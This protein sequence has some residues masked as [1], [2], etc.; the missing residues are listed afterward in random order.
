MTI[1]DFGANLASSK[2]FM[3]GMTSRPE[4]AERVFKWWD[5][6]IFVFLSI[7]SLGAILSFLLNWFS[8]ED[9]LLHPVSFPLMTAILLVILTNNQGRWFLLYYMRKPRP[10]TPRPGWKV[11]VVTTFVPNGEPLEMLEETVQA[12]VGLDYPHDTWVLDEG[13]DEKVKALCLK[14]GASHFSRKNLLQHKAREGTFQSDSKHGNYNVW[15][16]EV[17]FDGY[18]F[19]TTFDP[20][21]V[22]NSTFLGGVLSFFEDEKVAYVQAAQAYYNQKASFIA[23]GAAEETYAYYSSVQMA[24][25]GM[26]YPII[27]GSH[28]SHRVTAL[29]EIGGFAAHDADDLLVTLRYQTAGWRGVYVP[30]ILARGLTP[31]DWGGYLQQQRRWARSVLD[32]KLRQHSESSKG[33]SWKSRIMSFL[34]GLNYLHRAVIIFF[35]LFLIGLMLATGRTPAVV[36]YLTIQK[37]G[38]LCAVLQLC[39]F[40]RQR[41]YLD[42]RN[43]WGFHWRVALLQYAKWPWFLLAL[44]DVL[45]GRRMPYALT[46][47][48][49]SNSINHWL[50]LPNLLIITFLGGAWVVGQSLAVTVHP[51]VYVFATVFVVASIVLIWTEFWDFPPPYEKQFQIT[52]GLNVNTSPVAEQLEPLLL[53]TNE[54]LADEGGDEPSEI[55]LRPGPQNRRT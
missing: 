10:M 35:S 33:L 42:P 29:K 45:F 2:R 36:S 27:V 8:P 53:A 16:H 39:E 18:D 52:P 9:W 49:R 38:I 21:H 34:H 24:S 20:D 28:N 19:I 55:A 30:Q 4:I 26:G 11:A 46:S 48:V 14:L 7:L 54:G 22:P 1:R 41:F 32:I 50:L 23:R 37:L 25:Y 12:L 51:L 40:Y 47:K 15:L 6:P 3:A 31:V 17:G 13:D 44:L 5:Y 43:E